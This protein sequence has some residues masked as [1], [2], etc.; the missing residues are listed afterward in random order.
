MAFD[1]IGI[2][3]NYR[4]PE[5]VNAGSTVVVV[6]P[7]CLQESAS[8]QKFLAPGSCSAFC[9]QDQDLLR[10]KR[11]RALSEASQRRRWAAQR[12]ALLYLH[13]RSN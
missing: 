6:L 8:L 2:R 3:R 13:C 10:R 7:V 1:P 12:T 5:S 9:R 4:T 11:S